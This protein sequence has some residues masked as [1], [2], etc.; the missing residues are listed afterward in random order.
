MVKV[1]ELRLTVWALILP[2]YCQWVVNADCRIL[3]TCKKGD[4]LPILTKAN[5]KGKCLSTFG[6]PYITPAQEFDSQAAGG[7]PTQ[8][9]PAEGEDKADGSPSHKEDS[10][11]GPPIAP[12]FYGRRRNEQTEINGENG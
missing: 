12:I 3:R 10:D 8:N 11:E 6:V 1:H 2:A 5:L 4:E 7:D 9:R